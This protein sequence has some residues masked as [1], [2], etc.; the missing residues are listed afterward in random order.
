MHEVESVPW[1]S[2]ELSGVAVPVAE[3][4]SVDRRAQGTQCR[5]CV[6]FFQDTSQ[7]ADD[8][9]KFTTTAESVVISLPDAKFGYLKY[10]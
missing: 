6:V 5:C 2:T 8:L 3:G 7:S 4:V 10:T 9:Q 1:S